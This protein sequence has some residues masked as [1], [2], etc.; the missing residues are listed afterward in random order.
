MSSNRLGSTK[1]FVKFITVCLRHLFPLLQLYITAGEDKKSLASV[2]RAATVPLLDQATCRG[3][4]V[5]GGKNQQIL[6]SM[7]CA[8]MI[9]WCISH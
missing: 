4:E 5:N 2:L 9:T 6:D 7:L 3:S 8:G 1:W